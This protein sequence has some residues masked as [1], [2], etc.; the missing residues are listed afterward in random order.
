MRLFWF[1]IGVG[2][3]ALFLLPFYAKGGG[4]PEQTIILP[5]IIIPGPSPW[6]TNANITVGILAG[7]IAI[8]LGSWTLWRRF[9]KKGAM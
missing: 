2:L 8:I 3:A 4:G 1:E 9:H 5:E 7:I 6:L